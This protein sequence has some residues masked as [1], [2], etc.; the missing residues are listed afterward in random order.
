MN[1]YEDLRPLQSR[2]KWWRVLA[3][4]LFVGL[5]ARYWQLQIV[6]APTYQESARSNH[7]RHIPER[8][9]RGLVL[10]RS[11]QILAENRPSFNLTME[12]RNWD[13][14]VMGGLLELLSFSN[15][16]LE[17]LV[18]QRDRASGATPVLVKED[19]PLE[20]VALVES[21]QLELPGAMIQFVPRRFYP[22]GSLAAHALGYVGRITED[23]LGQARFD[24]AI[25][26]EYVG[27]SGIELDYNLELMGQNGVQV[28]VVNSHG[29]RERILEE[30]PPLWG[31]SVQLSLDLELQQVTEEAFEDKAGAAVVLDPRNGE[32][33]ALAS[34]PSF[35]PNFF[36]GRFDADE[37][38]AVVHDEDHRLQNR[39]LQGR[40][41]PGSVFKLILAAAALEE[42]KISPATRLYCGGGV[43]LYNKWF[44]CH[45]GSGHGFV[46]L[47]KAIVESCNTYFYQIGVEL[48]IETIARYARE[49]GL[50]SPTGVDLPFEVSGLVPD[51]DWKRQARQEPWYAGETVSVA[52]GQGSVLVTAMQMAQIAAIVG[53]SGEVFRPHVF[54]RPLPAGEL[55]DP[56]PTTSA[57]EPIRR[58][59][60]DDSTWRVLQQAMWGVVNEGG[61][62]WRA[63][64]SGVGV[65]G[66]TGTAQVASMS[67]LTEREDEDRPQHLRNHAWFVG[68]APQDSPKLALAVL[69]EHGGQGGRAAA[70]IAQKIFQAYFEGQRRREAN[71][72]RQA[73]LVRN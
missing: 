54:L 70:P 6:R 50:G 57:G 27:Q 34:F 10:D 60:L 53:S 63:R 2:L 17:E 16:E 20:E 47:H 69:V 59:A 25:A 73:L 14:A 71:D 72:A 39:A 21:R 19:I 61:T 52:V 40:Y 56:A 62:G 22:L 37:W 3:V 36:S 55:A 43:R 9:P 7:V 4:T 23:Q 32:V 26:N 65:S 68:Y 48:K 24:G 18:K 41:A 64:V 12:R 13:E 67:N 28:V 5:C 45:R 49:F 33:M 46:D 29:R 42:E 38:Q 31:N 15:A 35:D 30:R 66:K 58:V 8:A 11:G 1:I 51:P 44:P